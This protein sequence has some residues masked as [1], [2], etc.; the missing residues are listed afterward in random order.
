[1]LDDAVFGADDKFL[2]L[3]FLGVLHDTGGAA[4]VVC[5]RSDFL[6]AFRV[7]QKF[8]V[9]V[10]KF[11]VLDVFTGDA[12]VRRAA[13]VEEDE[14]LVRALFF[15]PAAEVAVRDE[16]DILVRKR[17]HD[18]DRRGGCHDDIDRTF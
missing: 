9:R 13:A 7:H 1:M 14:F 15:D 5:E 12:T 2:I 11:R 16:E 3:R 4:G 17:I 18:A 10:K 8:C 6:A